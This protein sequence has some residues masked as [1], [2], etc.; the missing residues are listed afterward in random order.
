MTIKHWSSYGWMLVNVKFNVQSLQWML[1]TGDDSAFK[2]KVKV[3]KMII[4]MAVIFFSRQ[5][6]SFRCKGLS[7]YLSSAMEQTG[8]KRMEIFDWD[9][10]SRL[11]TKAPIHVLRSSFSRVT[12]R[13]QLVLLAVLWLS[14]DASLVTRHL[15]VTKRCE[16][17]WVLKHR[18]WTR[19]CIVNV[20]AQRWL[21]K[22][23]FWDVAVAATA[24]AMNPFFE[25]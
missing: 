23:R 8:K 4:W 7:S 18:D 1:T 5:S 24:W 9:E 17:K 16:H 13:S 20:A 12:I 2:I 22:A 11:L 25:I 21:T 15:P 6:G 3:T 19:G 10:C 14:C